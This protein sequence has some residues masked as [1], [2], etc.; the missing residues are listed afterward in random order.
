[1]KRVI[2]LYT[3]DGVPDAEVSTHPV[4][5]AD[6]L[7]L[8]MR[9]FTRGK[10][11]DVVLLLHGLTA[12]CDMFIMPEHHNLT[13]FLLDHGYEVWTL[14]S[15]M[16]NRH[17]YNLGI[18]RF[19]LDDIALFDYP[20]ATSVLRTQVGDRRVHVIAHCLGALA[21]TMS[22]AA[23]TVT[24]VTSAVVN[25]AGLVV[26]VPPWSRAKLAVGPFAAEYA[27]G[28]PYLN[29]QWGDEPR[30]TRGW[31]IARLNSLLHPECDVSACHML[32]LMWGTGWPAMYVHENLL[33]VTHARIGDLL[34]ASA[35][36]YD[37]HVRRMARTGRAVKYDPRNRAHSSLPDD[38]LAHGDRITTPLL[39]TSGDRNRI[40]G[41]SNK[42]CHQRL[43]QAAPGRHEYVALPGY[44]HIDP[45]LGRHAA[46]EVFP[47][48]LDFIKRRSL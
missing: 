32:S 13:T 17:S 3:L 35:V 21:L 37:R 29:P 10:S 2:P 7:G 19:T 46:V 48:M 9:R 15:R 1:M 22:L 44:G 11:G 25:S 34:Q 43:E 23:G 36:H 4:T 18:H 41:D 28:M 45:F 30:L 31:L 5:T 39:F 47:Q 42:I 14:D 27:L 26:R 20:A 24:G 33:P 12:S 40:F 38:Y 16:S 6:G 8:T